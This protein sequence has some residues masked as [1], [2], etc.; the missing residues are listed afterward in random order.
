MLLAYT[1][2]SYVNQTE[3]D[4]SYL[5]KYIIYSP[6]LIGLMLSSINFLQLPFWTGWNLYLIN[7]NYITSK[8]TLKFYYV[9]GT[10]AGTFAG[11]MGF[12]FFLNT[13][14]HNGSIFQNT[15]SL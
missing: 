10:L 1:F 3:T 2:Y 11:M 15:C 4:F 12:V 5:E 14:S 7:G 9:A 13:M 8:N 6:F